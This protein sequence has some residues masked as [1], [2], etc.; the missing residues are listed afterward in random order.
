MYVSVNN[1]IISFNLMSGE[2]RKNY[3]IETSNLQ[4]HH[5]MFIGPK[6]PLFILDQGFNVYEVYQ[7]DDLSD[8]ENK[9]YR[10]K[11]YLEGS[12]VNC[13]YDIV[14]GTFIVVSK[15]SICQ[16]R[17]DKNNS[18]NTL[19]TI[20]LE[21]FAPI[22]LS[23]FC[24]KT[25]TVTLLTG[26]QMVYQFKNYSYFIEKGFKFVFPKDLTEHEDRFIIGIHYDY[27]YDI[28]VIFSNKNELYFVS[29]Q[30]D[31]QVYFNI[32]ANMP[33][34]LKELK[35]IAFKYQLIKGRKGM[36]PEPYILVHDDSG[37][38]VQFSLAKIFEEFGMDI[39]LE[40]VK[41]KAMFKDT[42]TMTNE[43]Y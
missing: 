27:V 14:L 11:L 4:K 2:I 8:G 29:R 31:C 15:N 38:L 37:F 18:F 3:S 22:I 23:C 13:F 28:F 43:N 21:G 10:K 39:R 36:P 32:I 17:N 25:K 33:A 26:D 7:N 20:N 34:K 24:E 16:V 1:Q 5:S 42:Q 19:N 40:D 6:C 12:V 9:N 41:M 30:G 35:F